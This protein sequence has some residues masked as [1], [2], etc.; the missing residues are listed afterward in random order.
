MPFYGTRK[1]SVGHRVSK[2]GIEV[3]HAKVDLIEKLP[4]PTSVK[5]MRSFLGHTGFYRRFIK[6]FSKIANPLCKLLEKDQHFLFSDDCRFSFEELK[7]L[8]TVP[9]IVAPNWEQ[10]FELM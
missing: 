6:D 2:K 7:R 1:H 5:A 10:P 4:V 8:V 3:D 9:I